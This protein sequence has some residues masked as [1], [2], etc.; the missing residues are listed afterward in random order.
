MAGCS[1][2]T[3]TGSESPPAGAPGPFV[4]WD[5]AWDWVAR[6]MMLRVW[7]FH[8]DWNQPSL[9]TFGNRVY[10]PT[11]S[12]Q[13]RTSIRITNLA[14]LDHAAQYHSEIRC[15]LNDRLMYRLQ[16][17]NFGAYQTLVRNHTVDA[18]GNHHAGIHWFELR[19]AGTNTWTLFQ[20]GVLAPDTDN[21]W[22]GSSR[23]GWVGEY[24]AGLQP[25]E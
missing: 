20:Q 4:E 5:D 24:G 11:G 10:S 16:Y 8:V 25:F 14:Q 18:D 12:F 2:Q 19:A 1:R 6:R 22:M 7:N 15:N 3:W 9:S 21:R 13:R 23:D 17:R